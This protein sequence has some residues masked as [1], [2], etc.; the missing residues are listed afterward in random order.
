M[1]R[2]INLNL[3]ASII[4][5]STVNHVEHLDFIPHFDF[6]ITPPGIN[7]T[8]NYDQLDGTPQCWSPETPQ[9]ISGLSYSETLDTSH[10]A[11]MF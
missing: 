8:I 11:L 10:D 2:P 4:V 1:E 9:E 3:N 7:G 5:P 6:S